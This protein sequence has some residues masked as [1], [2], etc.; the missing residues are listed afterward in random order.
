M[1]RPAEIDPRPA[2]AVSAGVGVV[3]L[4]GLILW[5]VFAWNEAMD[6][7]LAAMAAV[8]ACCGPMLAWSLLVDRVHRSP[9]TGIDR[10]GRCAKRSASASPSSPGCGPPRG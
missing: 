3:G 4:A 5:T 6:G 2:S 1:P 7:P 8:L 9:S 10:S